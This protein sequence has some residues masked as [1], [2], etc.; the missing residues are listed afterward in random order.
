MKDRVHLLDSIRALAIMG[1]I[2][3]HVTGMV[4]T[5]RGAAVMAAADWL[6][7]S[8]A[9]IDLGLII[10]KARACFGFLFGVS[11]AILVSRAE[12]GGTAVGSFY[13]RRMGGL[14]VFGLIN[15]AF[16]FFGDILVT[17][18]MV[19]CALMLF[20]RASDRVVLGTG[21]VLIALPSAVAALAAAGGFPMPALDPFRSPW[22][23][24]AAAAYEGPD[25]TAVVRHNLSYPAFR[26]VAE[27]GTTATWT[28]GVLGLFLLGLWTARRGILFDVARHRVFLKR[29]VWTLTP[30]GALLV[31]AQQAG[32]V[33]GGDLDHL[34]RP[35]KILLAAA[36]I[37][38]PALGL[39]YISMFA[40]LFGDHPGPVQRLIAPLGRMSLT[41]Y[42]TSVMIAGPILYGYGLGIGARIGLA[43]LNALAI[44]IILVLL[45]FARFWLARFRYGPLEWAWRSLTYG[46]WQPLRSARC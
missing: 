11:F 1:V 42:L 30:S 8:F 34:G 44:G 26:W 19:G 31:A 29:V 46:S 36:E 9:A 6:D 7:L 39:A 15:Q 32:A 2:V 22:V 28:L 45:I 20:R 14:L 33:W 35:L 17:Y 23:T 37:G 40:L 13:L 18:A 3:I 10:D 24:L 12:G 4:M 21:L 16:F 41:A 27:T 38:G 5:Y 43:E 25:A